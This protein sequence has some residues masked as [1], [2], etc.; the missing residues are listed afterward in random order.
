MKRILYLLALAFC[1]TALRAQSQFPPG[2]SGN[3]LTVAHFASPPSSPTLNQAFLFVDAAS[4][5]TCGGG[6]TAGA[7]CYW[8]G[9]A[10][11]ATSGTSTGLGDPGANGIVFRS[12]AGTSTDATAT[13]MSGPNFCSDAG[14]T[15]AYACS[16]S[17]VIGSYVA[18]TI[19]WFKANTANTGASSINFN[20]K[21]ALAI[22]TINGSITTDTITGDILAGQWVAVFYDGTNAQ[23]VSQRGTAVDTTSTQTL[24]N[25]T[26]DGVPPTTMAFVDP[27]S[28]IQTQ[29]N[30]RLITTNNLSDL[31]NAGTARTNLGLGTAAVGNTGTSGAT[32]PLLNGNNTYSGTSNFTGT[33]EIGG[34]TETF[35]ASGILVGTTDTQTLTN[36][37]IAASEVN[38]G[39]LAAARL[40][41]ATALAVG[42]VQG[43]G[44]TLT[45]TAGVISCTTA[46]ASQIGCVKPDGTT[47]TIT[48]GT[49]SSVMV[50]GTTVISGGTTQR[51][52][53]DNG[54]S[55]GE[56]AIPAVCPGGE[57][58]GG[59]TISAGVLSSNCGTP[60]GGG[61]VSNSGTPTNGQLAQWT[62]ATTIQGITLGTGVVTFLETSSPANFNSMMTG[63]VQLATGGTGAALTASAGAI[64]YSN[65]STLALL[66]STAYSVLIT[67]ATNPQYAT[68]TANGQ[69]FMSAA[70][71][72]ATTVPSFQSCPSGGGGAD[73]PAVHSVSFSATPTFTGTSGTLGTIDTF[74]LGQLS[75]SVT[76]ITLS[77]VTNGQLIPFDFQQ[78]ATGG[79]YSV[80]PGS[81]FLGMCQVS[82]YPGAHTRGL[83][84]VNASGVATLMAGCVADSG[85]A[86][87]SELARSGVATPTGST[88]D[89][90][91]IDTSHIP[92]SLDST[93]V[94]RDMVKELTGIRYGNG[95]NTDDSVATATQIVS[96]LGSQA[97][98]T[99]NGISC[100]LNSTCAPYGGVNVYTSSHTVN[101]SGTLNT[102]DTG[103]LIV[104]NCS[105][106]C[107][108]TFE[109]SPALADWWGVESIGSTLATVSLNSKNFNGASS[110]PLLNSFRDLRVA[111]DGSNYFGDAPLV[112]GTNVTFTP[113]SNGFTVIAS[114][115]G[116]TAFSALTSSTNTTAAMLVGT[117]ASLGP[118]GTGTIT[119][120]L[121]PASGSATCG[122]NGCVVMNT[123]DLMYH[124]YTGSADAQV[125]TVATTTS[126]SNGNCPVWSVSGSVKQ[127]G[128]GAACASGTVNN[129]STVGAMAYYA[130][131]GTAVSPDTNLV[132]NGSGVLTEIA[133]ISTAGLGMEILVYQNAYSNSSST[134]AI[135]WTSPPAGDYELHYNLDLHTTCTTGTGTL[136]LNA[137]YTANASRSVN[138]GNWT[139]T[140]TQA[141]SIPFS[142]VLH[143]H[144]SSGNVVVTPNLP[145]P[146]PT[147]TATWDGNIYMT[148]VN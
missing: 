139:L 55:L 14:S 13:Q 81:S 41:L 24:T 72:Y 9:S 4:S 66:A 22:K 133:G 137:T 60:A 84:T 25:K 104:M 122:V 78:A 36:K 134:S 71:N 2:G 120:N 51:L 110:V 42:G 107:A 92:Y 47:I 140:S 1:W 56:T 3:G 12:G 138:T 89:A 5:G 19:Y 73:S 132:D 98:I 127:L 64:A 70:S 61:N 96:A 16:L 109:A 77:T 68:P 93:G 135:T 21:G 87:L 100:T 94:Y 69:C 32:V 97:T 8:N 90:Q 130:A 126:P 15:D 59:L 33:F 102:T 128:A 91:G 112:A 58:S 124:N 57:F 63:P 49:I 52:V 7:V 82:Q 142:G 80:T 31:N 111:S 6:G 18:G 34:V 44:S 20:S 65:S 75:A 76:G 95:A 83:M 67:G 101:G 38:S 123:T 28:S 11:T 119:A 147:G 62:N 99:V 114:S 17:P 103:K 144:V 39:T 10:F 115:S 108:L 54:G 117:E 50:V 113:A 131:T 43:D 116:S 146:C 85:P 26:V 106:T 118:T 136:Y 23:M 40:P 143:L 141:A 35:P 37:S 105:S 125:I 88:V 74:V 145:T 121:V 148:R 45:I 30:N 46:T 129:S 79:P 29:L 86:Y 27:T 48:A 53:F